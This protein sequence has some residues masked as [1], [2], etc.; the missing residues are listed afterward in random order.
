MSVWTVIAVAVAAVAAAALALLVPPARSRSIEALHLFGLRAIDSDASRRSATWALTPL[1][2]LSI[3]VSLIGL[4]VNSGG[5][6]SGV[7]SLIVLLLAGAAMAAGNTAAL[8]TR[9]V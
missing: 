4:A 3:G 1:A 2:A 9:K 6:G 8:H 5:P 7:T